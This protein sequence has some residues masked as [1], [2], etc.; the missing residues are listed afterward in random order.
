MLETLGTINSLQFTAVNALTMMGLYEAR[1][2]SGNRLLS[3]DAQ[4]SLSQGVACTG[5]LVSNYSTKL[6]NYGI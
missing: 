6:V 5:I 3:V 1:G 2:V 4:L